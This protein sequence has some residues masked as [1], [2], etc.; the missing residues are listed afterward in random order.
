M[1]NKSVGG[2]PAPQESR[3]EKAAVSQH[4][5][6]SPKQGHRRLLVIFFIMGF[7]GEAPHLNSGA[8]QGNPIPN[9]NP[10]HYNFHTACLSRTTPFVQENS[11]ERRLW[12]PI[13]LFSYRACN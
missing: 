3:K 12:G 1:L 6:S 9:P 8:F 5:F 13:L 11:V 7:P 10:Y 2:G 4:Q